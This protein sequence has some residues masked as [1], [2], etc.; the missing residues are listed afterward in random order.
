M[1]HVARSGPILNCDICGRQIHGKPNRVVEGA[2]MMTCGACAS[3]GT[4]YQAPK[5][6]PLTN[7][8]PA[9]R[10]V[11]AAA[12]R[13]VPSKPADRRAPREVQELD[14]ADNYPQIIQKARRKHGL[15]QEDLAMKVKERLS[16]IQKIELGKMVPNMR[17]TKEL[18]HVLRIKLL[19]LTSEPPVPKLAPGVMKEVTLADVARIR[20]KEGKETTELQA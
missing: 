17:L 13:S 2:V 14:I 9:W 20:N 11:P 6:I 5:P 19:V 7:P 12:P 16:M 4:P 18:E 8:I 10:P 3:L 1:A 15:S